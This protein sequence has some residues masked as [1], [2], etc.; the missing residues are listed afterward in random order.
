[1]PTVSVIVAAYQAEQ[2]IETAVRS[3]LEQTLVDIELVVVVDGATD[4]T[5]DILKRLASGDRRLRV[6]HLPEN[7][8]KCYARNVGLKKARGDWIAILDA[9]DWMS[10]DRL[11][12]LHGIAIQHDADIVAD[13]QYFIKEGSLRPWR[14]L[15]RHETEP[16]RELSVIDFVKGDIAGRLGTTGLLKP[17]VRRSLIEANGIRY[18]EEMRTGEDFDFAMRC[19]AHEPRIMV[20][21]APKYFYRIRRASTSNNRTLPQ[22]M[23]IHEMNG[24]VAHGYSGRDAAKVRD[25]LRRRGR[26]IKKVIQCRILAESIAAG[27][28]RRAFA[29][30]CK[31]ISIVPFIAGRMARKPLEQMRLTAGWLVH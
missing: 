6:F 16:T 1:M 7:R 5:H 13:N 19:L 8:G 24:R 2:F 14:T 22:L 11:E 30:L 21:N 26:S 20:C 15:F 31:N 9:D 3:V 17:M 23:L 12:A 10:N 18:N 25:L 28:W 27:R 4:D 29:V